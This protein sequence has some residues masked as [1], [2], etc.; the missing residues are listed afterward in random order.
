VVA[1]RTDEAILDGPGFLGTAARAASSRAD[2]AAGRC[3]AL[4]PS[5]GGAWEA[6]VR[7]PDGEA[8][9]VRA[10][11]VVL[12]TGTAAPRLVP[13]SV[14]LQRGLGARLSRMLVLRGPLPRAAAIVPSRSAGGLFFASR[15][16]G[17]GDRVWLVSDGFSSPGVESPGPL[18]DGWWVCS[19]LERLHE[20]VDADVLA[21]TVVGGYHAAKSRVESSPTQVPAMGYALDPE[22]AFVSLTPSKWST[23]PTSAV[24]ALAALI[25]DPLPAATRTLETARLL[26][27]A[28]RVAEPPFAETWQTL[29][30][31]APIGALLKPGVRALR[32][33]ADLLAEPPA[34]TSRSVSAVA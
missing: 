19:V 32:L 3:V 9:H 21:H 25:G 33:G 17:A 28:D 16:T 26:E 6:E 20:L 31:W 8:R 15:E 29:H 22:R 12:A 34:A 4:R 30:R 27:S 13:E 5:W 24:H 10:R 23:T 18:T 11:A 7:G 1:V 14:R 2:V